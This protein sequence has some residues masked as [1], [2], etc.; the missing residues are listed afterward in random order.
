MMAVSADEMQ[1]ALPIVC[2]AFCLHLFFVCASLCGSCFDLHVLS[3]PF[4]SMRHGTTF[5]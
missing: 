2:S 4:P 5:R 1:C 3:I